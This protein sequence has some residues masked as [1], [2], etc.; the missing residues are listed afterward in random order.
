MAGLGATWLPGLL[1]CLTVLLCPAGSA[2]PPDSC[3]SF[4]TVVSTSTAVIKADSDVYESNR[5]YTMSI[6]VD[7]STSSV[8]LRALDSNG[9]AVGLW[10]GVDQSCKS[11]VLY[12]VRDP[13][14]GVFK[15]TW[16]SPRTNVTAAEIQAFAVNSN[17]VATFSSLK[18]KKHAMTTTPSP[19]MISTTK[20][21]TARVPSTTQTLITTRIPNATPT[22]DTTR[23]LANSIFLSPITDAVQI[24]LVFLASKLLF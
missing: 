20:P 17:K 22:P 7:N 19:S 12:L 13:R 10:Y 1:L 9:S 16:Q 18:L 11:S 21:T 5:A 23:S 8:V 6:P 24:L 3:M 2:D 4:S 14:A 15:A